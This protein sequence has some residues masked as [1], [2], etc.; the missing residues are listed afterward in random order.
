[1]KKKILVFVIVVCSLIILIPGRSIQIRAEDNPEIVEEDT[2]KQI[3]TKVARRNGLDPNDLIA[4]S[5][6]ESSFG[7]FQSGDGGCSNGYFHLNH[8]ADPARKQ[9]IGDIEKEA[10][11]VCE[12]LI[13]YGY[14]ENKTLAFARYN[15]PNNPNFA[16]AE[17]VKS[18]LKEIGLIK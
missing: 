17:K 12:L 5:I 16:Y 2:P 8:C 4:I 11:Y 9:I 6:Q 14:K 3:I 13:K 18:R 15:S 1:M 10:Q 7:K